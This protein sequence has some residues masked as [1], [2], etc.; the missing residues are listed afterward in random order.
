M[1]AK[2][3]ISLAGAWALLSTL[4]LHPSPLFAQGS[5]TP[6]GP[7]APTMK[8][9]AQIEPRTAITNTGAVTLWQP[10]SYYLSTNITVSSGDAI[11]I[12]AND[13]TLDLRGFTISSTAASAAG[14][15]IVMSGGYTNVAIYNGHINSGVTNNGGTYSGSGFANGIFYSGAI[16]YNVRVK[17]VSIT[18]V[19]GVGIYL[20]TGRSS[21]VES[22][23]VLTAGFVG[24]FADVVSDSRAN[25]CGS[26]I[27]AVTA[28]NSFGDS[29][30]L[31]YGVGGGGAQNCYGSSVSGTGIG[32]TIALNCYG[33]STSGI[34][35]SVTTAENCYGSSTS[36]YGLVAT[37]ALN[38][39]GSSVT[40]TGLVL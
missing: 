35:L 20:T 38:C 7:P 33:Y 30:G 34:G 28:Q 3:L 6:P 19:S 1:K 14:T 31:S 4:N 22:C 18:G 39:F 23:T 8:S 15:A 37:N 32:T 10:G 5:L 40:A 21:L 29:S 27:Y 24:I 26:G 2:P 25:N 13:V 11:T 9:L 36:G 12:A 17:D 16:P